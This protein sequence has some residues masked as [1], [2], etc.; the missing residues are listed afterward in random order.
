MQDFPI[1]HCVV[2]IKNFNVFHVS[3]VV[4]SKFSVNG[5]LRKK[6]NNFSLCKLPAIEQNRAKSR[7]QEKLI[8]SRGLSPLENFFEQFG[9]RKYSIL[10]NNWL[11]CTLKM[12]EQS[13]VDNSSPVKDDSHNID[14]PVSI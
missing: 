4:S 3:A 12:S 6:N 1:F 13:A 7:I 2:R 14:T 5:Q 8:N 10:I 11:N 9:S